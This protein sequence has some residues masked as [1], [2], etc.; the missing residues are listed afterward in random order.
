MAFYHATGG[1]NW[2]T[3]DNWL[4]AAP[5]GGWH[6]VT[7]N[8]SGQVTELRLSENHLTGMIPPELGNFAKLQVLELWSNQLTGQIPSELGSLAKLETLA[9][10]GNQLHWAIPLEL[11]RLAN[12]EEL[13]L[14]N[15]QLTGEIPPALGNLAN[16]NVL[17]LG[18]SNQLT[19]GIPAGLQAVED[20]DLD[21]LGL[22][23]CADAP[24]PAATE[25]PPPGHTAAGESL[26]ATEIPSVDLSGRAGPALTAPVVSVAP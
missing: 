10:G 15:N 17:K 4:S 16:L 24:R 23:L 6:G 21:S 12:L 13:Y 14:D 3:N 18:G 25:A 1:V 11:G 20:H 2:T 5:L 8:R 19:G 26:R 9:L 7:T 22:P